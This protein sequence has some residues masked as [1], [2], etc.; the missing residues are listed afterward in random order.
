MGIEGSLVLEKVDDQLK[1]TRNDN[2]LFAFI[3]ALKLIATRKFHELVA[4]V[5][6]CGANVFLA[7]HTSLSLHIPR[8]SQAELARAS[9]RMKRQPRRAS[10]MPAQHRRE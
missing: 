1:G 4:L 8:H 5:F 2:F 3:V 9:A 10:P 7:E 6:C